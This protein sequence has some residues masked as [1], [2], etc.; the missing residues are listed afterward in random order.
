AGAPG[1]GGD[2]AVLVPDRVERVHPGRDV[3]ER[4]ADL[5]AAGRAPALRRRLLDGV[6]AFCRRR[7]GGVAAGD[8]AVPRP[9]APPRRRPDARRGQGLSATTIRAAMIRTAMI[10]AAMIR[11]AG[12][13]GATV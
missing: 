12:M 11:A 2:R 8:G 13:W 6:G 10:R 1:A 5:H 7:A 4:S 9:R 3:H